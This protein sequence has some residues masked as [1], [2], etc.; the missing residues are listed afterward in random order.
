MEHYFLGSHLLLL[1]S[2]RVCFFCGD[3]FQ[4]LERILKQSLIQ[5]SFS[6]YAM[7]FKYSLTHTLIAQDSF[8]MPLT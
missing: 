6:P 1:L 8:V 4:S 3:I 5:V 2:V 7:L